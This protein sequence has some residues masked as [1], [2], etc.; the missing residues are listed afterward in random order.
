[1]AEGGFFGDFVAAAAA[2]G[3]VGKVFGR[4]VCG[5]VS[6]GGL[7]AYPGPALAVV[8]E[9]RVDACYCPGEDGDVAY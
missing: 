2:A 1:M 6:V 8:G 9:V 5:R 3:S 7:G 4:R